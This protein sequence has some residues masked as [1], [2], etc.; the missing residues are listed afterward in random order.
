MSNVC[1]EFYLEKNNE[2]R[3]NKLGLVDRVAKSISLKKDMPQS[4]SKPSEVF[5]INYYLIFFFFL[6]LFV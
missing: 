5:I 3:L 1:K 6:L 2:E 4:S